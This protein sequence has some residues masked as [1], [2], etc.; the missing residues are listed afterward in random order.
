MC[1]KHKKRK[2][3]VLFKKRSFD[4]VIANFK[5]ACSNPKC[6]APLVIHGW[7]QK[8]HNQKEMIYAHCENSGN[9]D[10]MRCSKYMQEICF[11]ER[12]F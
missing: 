3:V 1:R 6:Q 11:I 12:F 7:R 9:A 10:T 2:E 4:E 8:S 5:V